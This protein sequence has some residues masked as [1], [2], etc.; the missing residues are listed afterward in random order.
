MDGPTFLCRPSRA[1]DPLHYRF[2]AFYQRILSRT[3]M[4][5][6][7]L[8]GRGKKW[9]CMIVGGGQVV[10]EVTRPVSG[11]VGGSIPTVTG[12]G[13]YCP[14]HHRGHYHHHHATLLPVPGDPKP[15]ESYDT[16]GLTEINSFH[17]S[18][19]LYLWLFLSDR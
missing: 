7:S 17:Y 13:H 4:A 5:G 15:V 10:S 2:A 3:G 14:L 16:E 12:N 1:S 6:D 19:R 9:L 18:L 8:G 11:S